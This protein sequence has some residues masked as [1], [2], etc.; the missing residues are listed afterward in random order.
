MTVAGGMIESSPHM[1]L[2][3][4][5]KHVLLD[6]APVQTKPGNYGVSLG[7]LRIRIYHD[8]SVFSST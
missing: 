1:G 6:Q 3:R 8:I 5:K 4:R 7:S 2:V